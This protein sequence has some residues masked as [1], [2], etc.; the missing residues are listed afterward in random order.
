MKN[1]G[2]RQ[3]HVEKCYQVSQRSGF[4]SIEFLGNAIFISYKVEKMLL[5]ERKWSVW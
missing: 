1:R 4:G 5:N 3:N 2:L